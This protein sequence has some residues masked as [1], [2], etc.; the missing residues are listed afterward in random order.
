MVAWREWEIRVLQ[1]FLVE[2]KNHMNG[3]QDR[4]VR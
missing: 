2:S 1:L 4:Q 3:Q